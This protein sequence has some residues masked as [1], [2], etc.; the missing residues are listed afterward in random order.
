[1][2]D[3]RWCRTCRRG[4]GS[5][6]LGLLWV[7]SDSV[8]G[9]KV[10]SPA[11]KTKFIV[12]ICTL[13]HPCLTEALNQSFRTVSLPR[14]EVF[15]LTLTLHFNPKLGLYSSTPCFD[16]LTRW[17]NVRTW[18]LWIKFSYTLTLD[19]DSILCLNALSLHSDSM[20]CLYTLTLCC[21]PTHCKSGWNSLPWYRPQSSWSCPH[22]RWWGGNWPSVPAA[23]PE[24]FSTCPPTSRF[25]QAD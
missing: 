2:S 19:I 6:P 14:S 20:S 13:T 25:L 22:R 24:T 5:R 18:L 9:N 23:L 11:V 12:I 10:C 17:L 7:R 8:D 1:M 3:R 15:R 21:N 16:F 4:S